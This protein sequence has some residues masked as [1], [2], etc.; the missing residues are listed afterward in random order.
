MALRSI[1]DA[2][3]AGKRVFVRF[4]LNV[5][6][7]DGEVTDTTRIER[8][9]PT[10][11]WLIDK[12]A[13]VVI[14]SHFD[15]PK[16]EVVPSMS[17]RP[18]AKI[19]SDK[20]GMPVTFVPQVTGSQV[21]DVSSHMEPGDIMMIENLRFDAGEE[22]NDEHFAS[23]LS[24][25]ADVYVNDSF[26]C[27]HRAHASI[28][29]ITRLLPAYAGLNLMKEIESLN[30]I[31][32]DSKSCR[33]ALVGGAKVS[34]KLS[35]LTNLVKK[36]D[37]L[38][39]GGGMANTFLLA[40]GHNLGSS[41]CEKDMLSVVADIRREAAKSDCTLVLPEDVRVA[42]SFDKPETARECQLSDIASGQ[43]VLD[44]GPRSIDAL[45]SLMNN[46]D[47]LLWNGPL[48]VFEVPP[49][50]TGTNAIARCA[51]RYC[52]D[53][54]LTTVAGGGDT[55][56]ALHHAGVIDDMSYVSTAGGAFLEWIEGKELP[57]VVA[58][59]RQ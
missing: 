17:L 35:V 34:T 21:E 14:A 24:K 50:D 8:A 29:A 48:G 49:F 20:I 9:L 30:K 13:S 46:I 28:E 41:L 44:I 42:D 22:S 40:E 7:R 1:S 51:A 5:P 52:K 26:S 23:Q 4:D 19:V 3:V 38:I 43:M 15:R 27:S 12:G 56:S 47:V 31:F 55:I 32:D 2:N 33:A 36:V 58:L 11:Q 57:G 45:E 53:G 25:L 54:K 18:I 37:Y 6:F 59:E 16:G 39:L 10:L